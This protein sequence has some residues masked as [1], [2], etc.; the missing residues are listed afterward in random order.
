[1]VASIGGPSKPPIRPTI[2]QMFRRVERSGPPNPVSIGKRSCSSP[3]ARRSGGRPADS[4]ITTSPLGWVSDAPH[5]ERAAGTRFHASTHDSR[6]TL[7]NGRWPRWGAAL[8]AGLLLLTLM[9]LMTASE[10]GA[11]LAQTTGWISMFDG[12]PSS[13]LPYN[14]STWDVLVHS[15][16]AA[17][18]KQ[19]QPMDAHH[20]TNCAGSPGHPPDH[21]LSRCRL[22]VQRPCHDVDQR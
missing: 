2:E 5:S 21:E 6:S 20:G 16:D 17:T 7:R 22:P 14:P 1:M 12:A 8:L 18:W 11:A 3:F 9:T 10:D 4:G 19:L 13:P 15:R